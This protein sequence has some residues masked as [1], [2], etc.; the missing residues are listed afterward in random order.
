MSFF[1]IYAYIFFMGSVGGWLLEV[2]FRKFFSKTNPNHKWINPGFCQGP[3]LPMYGFGLC[4]LY[5]ISYFADKYVFPVWLTIIII[6]VSMTIIEYISGIIAI[7]GFKI[8]LWDYRHLWGNFQGII[9]PLFSFFWGLMGAF[10]YFVIHP[11]TLNSILWLSNN[12]AFSFFIGLFFGVLIIDS[13]HSTDIANKL[14][15]FATEHNVIVIMDH[16][17]SHIR[18]FNQEHKLKTH[19]LRPFKS[20]F[21]LQEILKTLLN[22]SSKH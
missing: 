9:C 16:A 8:R 19:F 21:S 22:K 11:F 18:K 4:T 12:L 1:L 13:V 5:V 14:R 6:T 17:K 2:F 3:Y 15:T 20:D 7:K 10:Y